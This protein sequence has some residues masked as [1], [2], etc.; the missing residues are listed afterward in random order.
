MKPDVKENRFYRGNM[1][2][3][4]FAFLILDEEVYMTD[5]PSVLS[6]NI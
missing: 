4:I 6:T 1:L 5:E 3:V 2:Y